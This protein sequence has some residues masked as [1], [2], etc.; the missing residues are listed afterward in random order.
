MLPMEERCR[1]KQQL[2]EWL[3]IELRPN[4][5]G[6]KALFPIE[7]V[8]L[9][10]HQI[11]LRKTEFYTNTGRKILAKIY[12]MRLKMLQCRYGIQIPINVCAKGM[13]IMHVGPVLVNNKA[14]IGENVVLHVNSAIVAGGTNNDAPVLGRN[15]IVGVGAVILGNVHVADYTA[16]GAN[17]VV[18]KDVTEENTG[19][20]GVPAKKISNNGSKCWGK[21]IT[22]QGRK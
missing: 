4:L 10:R 5:S 13:R 12:F 19:V 18:N 6:I 15:V 1:T 8:V 20:A 16:I 9:N 7:P 3:E 17:A 22:N 14:T 2:K 11:L 21:N